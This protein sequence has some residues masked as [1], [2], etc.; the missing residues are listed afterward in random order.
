MTL[1]LLLAP[2][3]ALL[4]ACT[5]GGGEGGAD[6]SLSITPVLP[7]NQGALLTELDSMDLV[8]DALGDEPVVMPL[9]SLAAGDSSTFDDL[10][11]LEGTVLELRGYV[12]ST[13]RAYGRTAPL[14]LQTGGL[15]LRVLVS[16]VDE[17]GHLA[18]LPDPSAFGALAAGG[19]GRFLLFGGNEE[20]VFGTEST[21]SILALSLAPASDDL[22]FTELEVQMP[23][24]DAQAAGDDGGEGRICHSATPLTRGNHELVG[25]VLVAGGAAAL[26]QEDGGSYLPDLSTATW[27]S[28]LFDPATDTVET[29]SEAA[30]LVQPRCGHTATELPSGAVVLVGGLGYGTAGQFNAQATAEIFDP[31]IG[32]FELVDGTPDGPFLFHGAAALGS[33][34]VLVCGG[35]APSGSR[36]DGSQACD[37]V[38]NAGTISSAGALPE[39]L[40]HPAMAPLPDGRVLL[41]GGAVPTAASELFYFEAEVSDRAW[42]YDGEDWTETD[43]MKAPR[44][45]HRMVALPDGDVLVVGGTTEIGEFWNMVYG[46]AWAVPCAEVFD[47]DTERFALVGDC[48]LDAPAGALPEPV[49]LAGVAVDDAFGALVAGGLNE[50]EDGAKGVSLYRPSP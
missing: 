20:G 48:D 32:G 37:L 45:M 18:D 22:A 50:N 4:A 47:A 42:I 25:R 12:G 46:T 7:P 49:A 41:T 1:P 23:P 40:I 5:G 24:R 2:A 19:D 33:E 44:A 21:S 31:L 16:A 15:D 11:A 8:F 27:S 39:K 6:Y 36:W 13:L 9:S 3:A 28:F 43:P 26:M 29:L 10:P 30:A 17:V 14:T 34:G 35:L 38:G